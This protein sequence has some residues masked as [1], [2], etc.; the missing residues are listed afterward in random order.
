MAVLL[1][2]HKWCK[3]AVLFRSIN[4]SSPRNL[5]E[6]KSEADFEERVLGSKKP[7]VVD[8]HAQ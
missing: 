3:P 2:T 1:R 4:L 6:V 7:V 5:I 8:F